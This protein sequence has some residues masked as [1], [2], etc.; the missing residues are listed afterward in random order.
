LVPLALAGNGK[1]QSKGHGWGHGKFQ[2]QGTVVSADPATST[3]VVLVKAGSKQVKSYRGLELTLTVA[4][5]ARIFADNSD[6]APP[7]TLADVF[8][9]AVVHVGGTIDRTDPAAPVYLA[10]KVIVQQQGVAPTPTPTTDPTPTMESTP[11]DSPSA[12]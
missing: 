10:G 11:T 4:A 9:G 6:T 12:L 1:G 2:L 7:L 3:L 5:G 8:P